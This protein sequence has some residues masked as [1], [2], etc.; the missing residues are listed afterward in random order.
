MLSM[1]DKYVTRGNIAAPTMSSKSMNVKL[2]DASF[3]GGEF[4]RATEFWG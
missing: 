1:E 2:E 4:L 3:I